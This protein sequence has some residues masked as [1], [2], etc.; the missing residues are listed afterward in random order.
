MWSWIWTVAFFF[1]FFSEKETGNWKWW[2][3]FDIFTFISFGCHF[4]SCIS[5]APPLPPPILHPLATLPSR[6]PS[7][8]TPLTVAPSSRCCCLHRTGLSSV[9][10]SLLFVCPSWTLLLPSR[11][12][13][14]LLVRCLLCAIRGHELTQPLYI[15]INTAPV[16]HF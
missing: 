12:L 15:M 3:V 14:S 8:P 7:P 13:L 1:F 5:C 11:L 6:P 10:H 4:S 9:D 2:F 16:H